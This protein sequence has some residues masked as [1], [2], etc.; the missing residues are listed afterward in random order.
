MSRS[1]IHYVQRKE[2]DADKWNAC[3]DR[4]S[5]GL[6]YARTTYLDHVCEHWDALVADDYAAVMPLTWKKKYGFS[7]LY[8]PFFTSALGVFGADS[9]Y[10]TA[11][12]INSIP[13]RFKYWDIDLNESNHL[14]TGTGITSRR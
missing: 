6:I 4:A 11:D 5:N 12:F 7:Y 2:I 9:N 1:T 14:S 10:A 8:Q 3:I 13:A